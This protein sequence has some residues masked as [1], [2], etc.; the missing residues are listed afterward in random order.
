MPG[1]NV[2]RLAV[3]AAVLI[4]AVLAATASRGARTATAPFHLVFD[5]KHNAA[6]LHEGSFTT[7][8][9]FCSSG[10]AADVSIDSTTDTSLRRF[11][12]GSAGDFTAEVTP[13]PA[14][15]GGIGSWQIVAGSGSLADLRGKGNWTSTRLTGRPDDP[16][17][18]T[19]R[20]TWDGVADFDVSPP[21]IGLSSSSARKVN[22]PKG[23][24]TLRVALS[25]KD[26]EGDLVVY[27]VQVVDPRKPVHVLAYRVGQTRTGSA[28]LTVRVKP[29][30]RTRT[31]QVKIDAS[32]AVGNESSLAKTVRLR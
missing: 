22:R 4:T 30:K 20:S 23:A 9:S 16:A 3:L 10:S 21:T 1:V 32:D 8:S 25:L 6:L 14:E 31:L 18:I 17:T 15:H 28:T 19:F 24:Y 7:S 5:G 27:T 13:L 29:A 11:D 12:C 26:A 2:R